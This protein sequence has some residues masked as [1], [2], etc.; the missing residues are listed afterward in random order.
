MS[1]FFTVQ[2]K[3]YYQHS[4]LQLWSTTEEKQQPKI[5]KLENCWDIKGK[6]NHKN[7]FDFDVNL[8]NI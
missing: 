8:T 1:G 2:N 6:L 7:S 5:F 3:L 4:S